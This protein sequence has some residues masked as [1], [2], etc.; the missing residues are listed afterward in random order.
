MQEVTRAQTAPVFQQSAPVQQ[1]LVC[2]PLPLY[3]ESTRQDNIH[4]IK[5]VLSTCIVRIKYKV[6]LEIIN[7]YCKLI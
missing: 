3:P 6:M 5:T 7:E 1:S 4:F 2:Q